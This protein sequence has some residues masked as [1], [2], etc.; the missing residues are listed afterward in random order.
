MSVL[1]A[2][3]GRSVCMFAYL[4]VYV[5]LSYKRVSAGPL[6]T[7][8]SYLLLSAHKASLSA[9]L[10]EIPFCVLVFSD[11]AFLSASSHDGS[12]YC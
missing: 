12:L 5:Y 10:I 7:A 8:R 9:T 6:L 1:G 2:T 3:V 11:V 4:C